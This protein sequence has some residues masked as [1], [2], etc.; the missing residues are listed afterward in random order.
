MIPSR[1]GRHVTPPVGIDD[2]DFD[3]VG[4]DD[5]RDDRDREGVGAEG[6]DSLE[7]SD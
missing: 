4:G 7:F 6:R 1:N 2:V 5:A 3:R